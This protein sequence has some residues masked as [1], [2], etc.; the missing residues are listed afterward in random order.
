MIETAR[1]H[2]ALS[3]H[4]PAL[5]PGPGFFAGSSA[6]QSSTPAGLGPDQVCGPAGQPLRRSH[7]QFSRRKLILRARGQASQSEIIM[8]E[9]AAA[10]R[11][12]GGRW[13]K[14]CQ[15]DWRGHSECVG[16]ERSFYHI[17]PL[18]SSTN[19]DGNI[20]NLFH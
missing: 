7:Y 2:W 12:K 10:S 1:S 18:D 15:E 20:R 5:I 8:H 4:R 6:P 17:R 16:P 11:S 3:S 19:H 14:D 13:V 9:N